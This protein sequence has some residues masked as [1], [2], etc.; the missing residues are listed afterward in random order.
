MSP[1]TF[2]KVKPSAESSICEYRLFCNHDLLFDD[3]TI[4]AHVSNKLLLEIK[5]SFL[6]KCDKPILTKKH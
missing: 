5:G 4:L 3:F 6:I 2:K 1:S